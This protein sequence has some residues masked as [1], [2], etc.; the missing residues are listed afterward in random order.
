MGVTIGGS[1][2]GVRIGGGSDTSTW[3]SAVV[4]GVKIKFEP[5][6]NKA[7]RQVQIGDGMFTSLA[8]G[9]STQMNVNGVD[10]RSQGMDLW[11]NGEKVDFSGGA[12]APAS[13]TAQ[14]DA[15]KALEARFPGVQLAGHEFLTIGA[16]VLIAPGARIEGTPPGTVLDGKTEVGARAVVTGG[17]VFDST[18]LGSI[19]G[20]VVRDSLVEGGASISGGDVRDSS[21]HSG[22]SVSGGSLRGASIKPQAIVSG[23]S[24]RDTRV[25]NGAIVSGGSMQ[26]MTIGRGAIVSGGSLRGF[27]LGEGEVVSQGAHDG[28]L[29]A[30]GGGSS[31]GVTIRGGN[32]SGDVNVVIGNVANGMSAIGA[33]VGNGAVVIGDVHGDVVVGSGVRITGLKIDDL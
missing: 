32:F 20:G 26:D 3:Q 30:G 29:S 10:V 25:E 4:G 6:A 15:K 2:V 27:T 19:R 23:G 14:L 7:Q 24:L 9:M 22:A 16:D 17:Q 12:A 8:P 31:T 18:I 33:V 21:V 28:K 13:T 5:G 11:V 1:V